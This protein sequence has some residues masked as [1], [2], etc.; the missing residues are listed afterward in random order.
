MHLK[1]APVPLRGNDAVMTVGMK[2]HTFRLLE[3]IYW[4]MVD[5]E[6]V[7]LSL[8]T[9]VIGNQSPTSEPKWNRTHATH[10]VGLMSEPL[11]KR[12]DGRSSV[13][14]PFRRRNFSVRSNP[15]ETGEQ[16]CHWNR[17]KLMLFTKPLSPFR[18]YLWCPGDDPTH[19]KTCGP[20]HS[21]G[22]KSHLEGNHQEVG[23][24]FIYNSEQFGVL[25]KRRWSIA[26]R[27]HFHSAF[28]VQ[29]F[30]RNR[31]EQKIYLIFFLPS[32]LKL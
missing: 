13:I 15:G 30:S 23:C 20:L 18:T 6:T 28:P 24:A 11:P 32:I 17:N 14:V 4:A 31:S 12:N 22:D 21:E 19:Q 26:S 8:S 25:R 2:Q 9:N 27:I 10:S 5:M 16:V 7:C 29:F 3:I 1:S